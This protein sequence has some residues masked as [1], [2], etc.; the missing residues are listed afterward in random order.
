MTSQARSPTRMAR[1]TRKS[2]IKLLVDKDA[3]AVAIKDGLDWLTHQVTEHDVGIVYL[4]GHGIVDER[5]RFY[6]LAADSDAQR[7]RATAVAKDDIADALDET[8]GQGASVSRRLPCRLDGQHRPAID[9]RQ[10]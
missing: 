5:N 1:S 4:A 6:F 3:T 10:Q 9:F 7:L 8:C 2:T